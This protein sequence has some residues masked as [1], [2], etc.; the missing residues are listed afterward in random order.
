M[1]GEHKIMK[2]CRE[3]N[4][5]KHNTGVSQGGANAVRAGM[6]CPPALSR[7]EEFRKEGIKSWG[8]NSIKKG[9]ELTRKK[10]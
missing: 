5:M 10:T 3:E 4:L 6:W 1:P 7:D 2:V 9:G 8:M